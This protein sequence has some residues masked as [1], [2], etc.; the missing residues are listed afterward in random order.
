MDVM[1][2]RLLAKEPLNDPI[3]M[4]MLDYAWWTKVAVGVFLLAVA[5]WLINRRLKPKAF[6]ILLLA[7]ASFIGLTDWAFVT[8]LWGWSPDP[9]ADFF[10]APIVAISIFATIL[11]AVDVAM[12]WAARRGRTIGRRKLLRDVEQ[13]NQANHDQVDRHNVVQ[14]LGHD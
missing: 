10:F 1:A 2:Q 9:L 4:T 6:L 13:S 7:G 12:H 14:Q 3:Y 8:F 5:V 11:A